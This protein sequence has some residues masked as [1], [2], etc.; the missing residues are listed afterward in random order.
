MCTEYYSSCLVLVEKADDI[1]G[2]VIHEIVT[3]EPPYVLIK[4]NPPR[5]PNGLIIL[6][7]VFYRKVG[8][9]EVSINHL[10]QQA[11]IWEG[12]DHNYYFPKTEG[13]EG[14]QQRGHK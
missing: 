2:P 8:D 6:Y 12:G 14:G 1:P 9:T 4:W 3:A 10:E 5:S 7:E 13:G 11:L